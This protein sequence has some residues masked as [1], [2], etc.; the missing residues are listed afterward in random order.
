MLDQEI[1]II[2]M[3]KV[4]L[5]EIELYIGVSNAS[6]LSV[7][8]PRTA[9]TVTMSSPPSFK[10]P[11]LPGPSSSAPLGLP[12]DMLAILDILGQSSSS[13]ATPTRHSPL[14]TASSS[15]PPLPST[16]E[17]SISR[18]G[19]VGLKEEDVERVAG[20][21]GLRNSDVVD[22]NS[23]DAA[24]AALEVRLVQDQRGEEENEDDTLISTVQA[25]TIVSSSSSP[26]VAVPSSF[27]SSLST[28]PLPPTSTSSS[29]SSL[30][31]SPGAPAESAALDENQHPPP[32]PS[33]SLAVDADMEDGEI[34]D[35]DEAVGDIDLQLAED[36]ADSGDESE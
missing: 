18:S 25:S 23:Q 16:S 33:P 36:G 7:L 15:S 19:A 28:S 8:A 2:F 32:P 35:E 3:N 24:G 30:S 22:E 27:A 26:V 5:A 29:S 13:V 17:M 12:Q 14:T 10:V 31:S 20:L 4:E 6:L 1:S 34:D 21:V 9:P 11:T